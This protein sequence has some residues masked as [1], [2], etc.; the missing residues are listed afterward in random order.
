MKLLYTF[1]YDT[2]KN[3]VISIGTDNAKIYRRGIKSYTKRFFALKY[4]RSIM[5]ETV[6]LPDKPDE[7]IPKEPDE[8]VEQLE[9]RV[10]EAVEHIAEFERIYP[11]NPDETLE[12]PKTF[13][14]SLNVFPPSAIWYDTE[15]EA[16]RENDGCDTIY[17]GPV[18][19][20][21]PAVIKEIED[22][23]SSYFN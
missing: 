7:I 15:K 5:E 18:E 20:Y 4:L 21:D 8:T 22:E 10:A 2:G 17:L 23:I 13:Y 12:V 3:A 14:K 6:K 19:V 9:D 1:D 11:A 16:L